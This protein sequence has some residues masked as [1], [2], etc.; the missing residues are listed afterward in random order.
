MISDS[1]DEDDR[2][3]ALSAAAGTSS[4]PGPSSGSSRGWTKA[5]RNRPEPDATSDAKVDMHGTSARYMEIRESTAMA[6]PDSR[7]VLKPPQELNPSINSKKTRSNYSNKATAFAEA[8]RPNSVSLNDSSGD[9]PGQDNI[10]EANYTEIDDGRGVGGYVEVSE[11]VLGTKR[12]RQ[13]RRGSSGGISDTVVDVSRH[14]RYSLFVLLARVI[15]LPFNTEKE[16]SPSDK[17]QHALTMMEFDHIKSRVTNFLRGDLNGIRNADKTLVDLIESFFNKY[18]RLYSVHKLV[19]K[20]GLTVAE[21]KDVFGT[22]VDKEIDKMGFRDSSSAD[23]LKNKWMSFFSLIIEGDKSS[24]NKVVSD[25]SGLMDYNKEKMMVELR[26]ILKIKTQIHNKLAKLMQ[27][28]KHQKLIS[29]VFAELQERHQCQHDPEMFKMPQDWADEDMEYDVVRELT[30]Q[31]EDLKRN[32]SFMDEQNNNLNDEEEGEVKRYLSKMNYK[33]RKSKTWM[34]ERASYFGGTD[35]DFAMG[36]IIPVFTITVQIEQVKGVPIN[37]TRSQCLCTAHIKFTRGKDNTKK[38]NLE[39]SDEVDVLDGINEEAT[40]TFGGPLPQLEV[41]FS[42]YRKEGPIGKSLAATHKVASAL[43][44]L[45][46]DR[47]EANPE[48][49]EHKLVYQLG[50]KRDVKLIPVKKT[51]APFDCSLRIAL[52]LPENVKCTGEVYLCSK[53]M[54]NRVWKKRYVILLEAS[55]AN[56]IM[57]CYNPGAATPVDILPLEGFVVD[58]LNYEEESITDNVEYPKIKCLP[59]GVTS[60]Q[61][62][63]FVAKRGKLRVEM[64][65]TLSAARDLWLDKMSYATR[66]T[67]KPEPPMDLGNIQTESGII[68][69]EEIEMYSRL[70][71]LSPSDDVDTHRLFTI[72][73][74]ILLEHKIS[75]SYRSMGWYTATQQL[76]VDEFTMRYG[77][78]CTEKHLGY[79]KILLRRALEGAV[80]DPSLLHL[81]FVCTS[82]SFKGMKLPAMTYSVNELIGLFTQDEFDC[83]Y[84]E[85]LVPIERMLQGELKIGRGEDFRAA[86][87]EKLT[88]T[89]VLYLLAKISNFTHEFPFGKPAGVLESCIAFLERIMNETNPFDENSRRDPYAHI[90]ANRVTSRSLADILENSSAGGKGGKNHKPVKKGPPGKS[91]SGKGKPDDGMMSHIVMLMVESCLTKAASRDFAQLCSFNFTLSKVLETQDEI[92]YSVDTMVSN[93]KLFLAK[94]TTHLQTVETFF[95]ESFKSFPEQ[96]LL[97]LESIVAMTWTRFTLFMSHIPIDSWQVFSVYQQL[98]SFFVQSRLL[99]K[100]RFHRQLCEWYAPIVI[101]YMDTTES[102]IAASYTKNIAHEKW[103]SQGSSCLSSEDVFWKVRAL[104]NFIDDLRWPDEEFSQHLTF[105]MMFLASN[106][107]EAVIKDATKVFHQKVSA[108]PKTRAALLGPELCV[109]INV[110]TRSDDIITT[111]RLQK[112][113]AKNAKTPLATTK[114][115]KAL[116]MS[117]SLLNHLEAI[118]ISL[119]QIFEAALKEQLVELAKFDNKTTFIYSIYSFGVNL[120]TKVVRTV[121]KPTDEELAQEANTSLIDNAPV[122]LVKWL[123]SSSGEQSDEFDISAPYIDFLRNN[124]AVMREH[125]KCDEFV[126][127]FFKDMFDSLVLTLLDWTQKRIQV[128]LDIIQ[129]NSVNSL[130]KKSYRSF[131]MENLKV[132]QL[133]T[134]NLKLLRN[135]LEAE[136][137]GASRLGKGNLVTE[138]VADS[139]EEDEIGTR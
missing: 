124:L 110:L 137:R 29:L 130:L 106:V 118:H 79:L 136:E 43:F 88:E 87:D 114:D 12:K 81:A 75:D 56:F 91:G 49:P 10:E 71:Y 76:M 101:R 40:F 23:Q 121:S 77:I 15:A 138:G 16:S 26:I 8:H 63:F 66:Q 38:L 117:S 62:F 126:E 60:E 97:Y 90:V 1:D 108:I 85:H 20:G 84:P 36:S 54:T 61:L 74:E 112:F 30:K 122:W 120:K 41:T 18:M 3:A 44:Q 53:E 19:R 52:A 6:A 95:S 123:L 115:Y 111:L 96:L 11:P 86:I 7:G 5:A 24:E 135:R 22:N 33:I 134:D 2:Y 45:Y 31:T 59:E 105:R 125:I 103:E 127:L 4:A 93:F 51:V 9:M 82:A 100:T 80:I 47:V 50:V 21:V 25:A 129:L 113:L 119:S 14:D 116:K 104:K 39:Q 32:L 133:E 35:T 139:D 89:L 64:A 98:N 37:F 57:S 94:I 73:L 55:R 65:C 69:L 67:F 28:N 109:A 83:F 68:N 102:S 46:P 13:L 99:G 131:L 132:K 48:N 27:L 17:M 58:Y 70:S 107:L 34:E 42:T 128:Q 72:L 78:R 92:E